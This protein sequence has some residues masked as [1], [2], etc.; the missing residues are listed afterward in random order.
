VCHQAN[1]TGGSDDLSGSNNDANGSIG[2]IQYVNVSPDADNQVG[3]STNINTTNSD[4]D[5][6]TGGGGDGCT[7]GNGNGNKG[8][9]P[10]NSAPEN[11]GRDEAVDPNR[12]SD[13]NPGGNNV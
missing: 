7:S 10:G 12:N 1:N 9:D 8:C 5:N 2:T 4:S 6:N 3:D 13:D 11:S